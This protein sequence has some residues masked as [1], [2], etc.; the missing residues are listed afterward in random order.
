[1]VKLS[2]WLLAAALACA[3]SVAVT[4]I[5]HQYNFSLKG[6]EVT[7]ELSP[8]EQGKPDELTSGK[9]DKEN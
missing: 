2:S 5:L 3:T 7:I 8:G 1:M 9:V 6:W 4:A